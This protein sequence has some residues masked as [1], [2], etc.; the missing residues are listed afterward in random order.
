MRALVVSFYTHHLFQPWQNCSPHLAQQFLDFEP[1]IHYPQ[2]QMQAGV[3]G[4]NTLRVY[5]PVK[6]SYEHDPEGIF[7]RKWMPELSKIPTEFIHEPWKLTPIEQML[8]DF[9][10]GTDYPFPIVNLEEAR[11][12][13]S[14]FF[15]SMR[16][17]TEVKKDGIRIIEKHTL[18]DRNAQ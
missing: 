13:S 15:W 7:I 14:D 5:N 12:F 8:Y 9:E 11:R 17:E 3:T 2:I 16:K 10:I 18:P 4:I 6:N 1:G